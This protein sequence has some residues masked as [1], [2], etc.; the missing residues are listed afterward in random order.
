VTVHL[1][2]R[3]YS[4]SGAAPL[5]FYFAMTAGFGVM[6]IWAFTQSDWLVGT[7]ATLMVPAT[8]A[9]SRLMRR[10]AGAL[11]ASSASFESK[12]DQ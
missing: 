5:W 3:R 6:A 7:V 11:R 1:I 2:V 12:G 10:F 8:F 9:V 4:R